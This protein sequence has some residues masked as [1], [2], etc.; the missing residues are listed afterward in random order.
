M[1]DELDDDVQPGVVGR[2][3]VAKNT[4]FVLV[5]ELVFSAGRMLIFVLLGKALGRVELGRYVAVLGMVQLLFPLARVGIAHVMV[6]SIAQGGKSGFGDAWSKN[7]TVHGLGGIVG[8]GVSVALAKIL[9]DVSAFAVLLIAAAQFVGLGLQQAG[10]MAANAFGRAEVGLALN[11]AN[12]ILRVLA[13]LL[14]IQSGGDSVD[15]WALY[16]FGAAGL[17]VL[18]TLLIV[19]RFFEVQLKLQLPTRPDLVLATPFVFADTANSAQADIDKVVLGGLGLNADNGVYAAAY[20]VADLANL[21]LAA[22]VKATYGEFFRRG[23]SPIGEMLRYSKRLTGV[24][25]SYGAVI[26]VGL[27]V[28]APLVEVA[29]GEEFDDSI[30]ALRWIA[31]VPFIRAAQYFPANVLAGVGR[32]WERARLM[33]STA[34]LNLAANLALA[35]TMGWRG[36]A[37]STILAEI[38]FG[39]LLWRRVAKL[40]RNVG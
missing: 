35:P 22:L 7:V 16:L 28:A 38:A 33:G 21:P 40:D 15:S 17:G 36:A 34:L 23:D 26:G 5:A 27:W 20:R 39:V 2:A 14:F 25:M 18:C 4:S 12:T 1:N 6:R 37:L 19:G 3:S 8:A 9:F 13:V 29:M 11:G 10:G 24:A 30:S 32:Q 31:V